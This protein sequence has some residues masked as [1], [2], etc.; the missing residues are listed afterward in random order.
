M[1][2]IRASVFHQGRPAR[3][4]MVGLLSSVGCP[5]TCGFC[6]DWNSTYIL[7]S[8]DRLEADLRYI[9]AHMPNVLVAYHDP[10]FGVRFDET[11][12]VI[13]RVPK[14]RRNWYAMESS[15]AVLRK[16]VPA[17]SRAGPSCGTSPPTSSGSAGRCRACRP[18]SC[19]DWT[20]TAAASRWS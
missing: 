9:S 13:E 16:P 1:P 14:P 18:T 2:E 11:M 20:A 4:T 5:Y 17:R 3:A 19:S 7:L 8:P 10:N 15:L 6:T 12:D